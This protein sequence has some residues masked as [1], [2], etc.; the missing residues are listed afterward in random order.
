MAIQNWRELKNANPLN[1]LDVF[2]RV[3]LNS[4]P[5][6][7]DYIDD[8]I[9]STWGV[10]SL[11][12]APDAKIYTLNGT[13]EQDINDAD[14][15]NFQNPVT[16]LDASVP[17]PIQNLVFVRS[18]PEGQAPLW[19]MFLPIQFNT[20]PNP[21]SNVSLTFSVNGGT[22]GDKQGT[23]PTINFSGSFPG[24]SPVVL[25]MVTAGY[26]SVSMMVKYTADSIDYAAELKLELI[27]GY[28]SSPVNAG[29]APAPFSISSL[30]TT[31]IGV[32]PVDNGPSVPEIQ[33]GIG[34]IITKIRALASALPCAVIRT[35]ILSPTPVGESSTLTCSTIAC[36][37][38]GSTCREGD[39]QGNIPC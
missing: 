12:V 31:P 16:N 14:V 6:E 29:I 32:M 5:G 4:V 36:P 2:Q 11:S 22:R 13:D 19:G 18:N 7:F 23:Y 38:A 34:D 1:P 35:I 30:F 21:V 28:K 37:T 3:S 9:S 20:G 25:D 39:R 10:S 27:P 17:P 33:Y 26:G 15:W 8:L 24:S